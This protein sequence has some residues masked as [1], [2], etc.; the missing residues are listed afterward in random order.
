MLTATTNDVE[1]RV[2]EGFL[3]ILAQGANVDEAIKV[4]RAAARR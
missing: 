4:G 2:K 1:Q 3:G